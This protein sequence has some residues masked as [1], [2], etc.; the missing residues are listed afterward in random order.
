MTVTAGT[1][2]SPPSESIERRPL[3]DGRSSP[4]DAGRR[5]KSAGEARLATRAR[6]LASGAVLFGERGLH[7]VTSHEIAAHA[8]VAAGTFYNHFSDK[9]ELFGEIA[10]QALSELNR[11]LE[12]ANA[13]AAN[14]R[15][16]VRARSETLLDFAQDNRD[17]IRIL[18][19]REMDTAAVQ[20]RVLETLAQSVL[21]ERRAAI[22]RE[23][24]PPEIDPRVLAQAVVGMWAR[25]VA[26]WAEDPTRAPRAAVV[27][28][29]T[30]I[31][32]DGTHPA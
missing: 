13:G 17:L 9:H 23:E 10:S 8:G 4:V 22:A 31:Q 27:E 2:T 19:S 6:L 3:G 5:R 24:M 26:W 29:L 32:L 25:V 14:L 12:S 18:F 28:T 7:R 1:G 21:E 20:A 15:E 11:R 30:R 16:A